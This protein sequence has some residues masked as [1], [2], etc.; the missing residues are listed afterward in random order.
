MPSVPRWIFRRCLIADT[1]IAPVLFAYKQR[2]PSLPNACQVLLTVRSEAS[3]ISMFQISISADFSKPELIMPLAAS[4]D[5]Q[6]KGKHR[7][8]RRAQPSEHSTRQMAAAP[9]TT[10][11]RQ[12]WPRGPV[13]EVMGEV[14]PSAVKCACGRV[15]GEIHCPIIVV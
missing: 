1:K 8:V 6:K 10:Q 11:S 7:S 15:E 4:A 2:A 13:I 12:T 3:E 5:N 9:V 14:M